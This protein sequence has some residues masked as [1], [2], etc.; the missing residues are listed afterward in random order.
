MTPSS[1]LHFAWHDAPGF[2]RRFQ[3]GV[4]LHS[5]TMHSQE[6]LDF[7]PAIAS[8]VPIVRQVVDYEERQYEERN[9]RRPSYDTAYWTP[10]ASERE[11]FH[12]ER[13]QISENLG[14][15]PLVSLS[16]HDSIEAAMHLHVVE[17]PEM[18]PVSV[19][20]II[21]FGPSFFHLGVHNLPRG[22]ARWWMDA[23]AAYT[24][25]TAARAVPTAGGARREARNPDRL[26]S[27]AVG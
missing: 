24:R 11:A 23:L 12:L 5:H 18:V 19:E 22:E 20:W 9:G 1:Q 16:D 8:K 3:T 2:L 4:S 17:K 14:L 10:P 6:S 25:T 21:P 13:K 26:Q 7:L 27:S 15:A